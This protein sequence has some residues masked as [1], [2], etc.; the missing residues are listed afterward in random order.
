[1]LNRLVYLWCTRQLI[2]THLQLFH[3]GLL[4]FGTQDLFCDFLLQL[5]QVFRGGNNRCL[6]RGHDP[7]QGARRRY[8]GGRVCA[9]VALHSVSPV[10]ATCS[11]LL[12][13]L[14]D[15]DEGLREPAE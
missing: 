4:Q 11:T 9:V 5:E 15:V 7:L 2:N 13:L 14:T 12:L 10:Q 8:R 3:F 1:M 6:C